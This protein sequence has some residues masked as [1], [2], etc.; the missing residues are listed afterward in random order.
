[1]SAIRILAESEDSVTI[2]RNDWKNLQ[3]ELETLQ[4]C[5]AVAERRAY[6]RLL[7]KENVRRDYL[8]GSEAMRLLDGE[9]PVKVWREKRALSQRALAADANISSGYLAEIETN[10]K[11][12]SDDVYRKLG[13]ALRV[14]PEDLRSRHYRMRDPGY[15]PVLVSWSPASPGVSPG[16]RGAS[17]ERKQIATVGEALNYVRSQWSQLRNRTPSITDVDQWPIYAPEDLFREIEG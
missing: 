5:A 7:G 4:D 12:G 16:Q 9:S 8:S 3:E 14:S 15:G 10:R 13:G 17:I 1:M 11:P 6:E 2:S